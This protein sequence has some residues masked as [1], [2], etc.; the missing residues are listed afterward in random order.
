MG[1]EKKRKK[2]RETLSRNQRPHC[3]FPHL[4]KKLKIEDEGATGTKRG[5][6][7][8]RN[9]YHVCHTGPPPP[10][11]TA[12]LASGE[13]TLSVPHCLGR[14]GTPTP[15]P[16]PSLPPC[17]VSTTTRDGQHFKQIIS[18]A[19][20][21]FPVSTSVYLFLFWKVHIYIYVCGHFFLF[22]YFVTKS[23]PAFFFCSSQCLI[24]KMHLGKATARDVT[25]R[26]RWLLH[27]PPGLFRFKGKGGWVGKEGRADSCSPRAPTETG[28]LSAIGR[29]PLSL[30][31]PP[32]RQTTPT[33]GEKCL[34]M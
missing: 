11:P 13:C 27:V 12:R 17:Y 8:L 29:P 34:L 23:F 4:K 6:R 16:S 18:N 26:P 30:R 14:R 31:P 25:P 1:L 15:P 33:H 24:K 21:Y 7:W 22:K 32:S 9:Q 20:V 2:Q 19:C 10:R 3:A 5:G 28:P